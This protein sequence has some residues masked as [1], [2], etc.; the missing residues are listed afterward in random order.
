MKTERRQL[1]NK[2]QN[3]W[4]KSYEIKNQD[5]LKSLINLDYSRVEVAADSAAR[6][7]ATRQS[8]AF[9]KLSRDHHTLFDRSS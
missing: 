2:T 9:G 8:H 3:L 6:S 7:L 5:F 4:S 1:V